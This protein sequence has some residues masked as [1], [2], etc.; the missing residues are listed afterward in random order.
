MSGKS[1]HHSHVWPK[2]STSFFPVTNQKYPFERIQANCRLILFHMVHLF[3]LENIFKNQ[4][5]SS[6]SL[7]FSL[8]CNQIWECGHSI[9]FYITILIECQTLVLIFFSFRESLFS[10]VPASKYVVVFVFEVFFS[11]VILYPSLST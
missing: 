8:F 6:S 7:Q 4:W 11:K 9:I 5:N 3:T 1:P 10:E 2:P